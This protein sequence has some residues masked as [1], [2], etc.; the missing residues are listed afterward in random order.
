[1][2]IEI[3]KKYDMTDADYDKIKENCIFISKKIVIDKFFDTS[4]YQLFS[5]KIKLRERNWELQLKMKVSSNTDAFSKSIEITELKD[6]QV[7]L[8]ELGIDY[9]NTH[10]VLEISTEV[11]KFQLSFR[12][13]NFTIDIQ[14]YK[15]DYRYEVELELEEDLDV[16][17]AQLI[18]DFRSSIHLT[19]DEQ[20]VNGSKVT[21]CAKNEN[22]ALYQVIM[23]TK[24]V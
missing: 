17:P 10:Q 19:S 9:N 1:M 23:K 2:I 20:I 13:Y 11:E 15:Y 21:L 24:T 18:N 4:D 5:Q 8:S 6:V 3:E 14:K 7:K 22:P 12:W 16:D